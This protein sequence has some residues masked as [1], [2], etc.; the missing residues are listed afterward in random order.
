MGNSPPRKWGTSLVNL[1]IS[2]DKKVRKNWLFSNTPYGAEASCG[3]YSVVTTARERGLSP[4]RYVEWLLEELP[5]AGDLDDPEV[6][7]R[8]L[9]W[10]D[11][12]PGSVRVP[13][14]DA[15]SLPRLKRSR[16]PTW[17]RTSRHTHK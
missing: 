2:V 5:L 3:M 8:Y 6:V 16:S 1:E 17:K 13:S 14:A 10:S 11:R 12:V 15:A 7:D 4:M 9:L